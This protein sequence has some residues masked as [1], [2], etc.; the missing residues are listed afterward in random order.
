MNTCA[1]CK[2]NCEAKTLD[3]HSPTEIWHIMEGYD[4]VY[5][6]VHVGWNIVGNQRP[7][8]IFPEEE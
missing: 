7:M 5:P 2:K 4:D 8:I 6:Y 1:G 3:N